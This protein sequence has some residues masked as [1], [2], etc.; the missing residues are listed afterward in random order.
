M[1]FANQVFLNKII[2]VLLQKMLS[3]NKVIFIL[4]TS[5]P[6][7]LPTIV[8]NA[9]Y[10]LFKGCNLRLVRTYQNVLTKTSKSN[11]FS[12]GTARGT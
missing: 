4:F 8:V 2:Q 11:L 12:I 7:F 3:P 9:T 5:L 1:Y 10:K 6:N